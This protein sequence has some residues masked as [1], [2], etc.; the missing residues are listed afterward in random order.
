M[1]SIHDIQKRKACWYPTSQW[2][3]VLGTG[4]QTSNKA[5]NTGRGVAPLNGGAA[6]WLS[7]GPLDSMTTHT[8]AATQGQEQLSNQ[9]QCSV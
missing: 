3:E 4:L 7:P 6:V 2:H 1:M 8:L 9:G 5:E